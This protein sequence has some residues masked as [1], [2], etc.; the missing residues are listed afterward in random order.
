MRRSKRWKRCNVSD[1]SLAKESP[2][3]SR[4][5]Q[6]DKGVM[7]R[8]LGVKDLFAIGYG[9]LG[10][11][12]YYAL[13]VTALFALGATPISLLIAGLVFTCT[14]LT[15]AEI[16]AS[17]H[18]SGG[19]ASFA[20]HAFNDLISFIAGWGLLLDYVVT[21]AISSFAVAPYLA[22]FNHAFRDP[23]F[24]SVFTIV[25]IFILFCLNLLGVRQ[26]TRLSFILVTFTLITQLIIIVIGFV[27]L[28]DL[29]FIVEHLRINVPGTDWSPSW[30]SFWKGTAMA[31]VAY[32][33][34]ESIAQLGAEA[35]KPE[36]TSP[37]AIFLTMTV[38]VLMYIAISLVALSALPPKTL[39]TK[40]VDDPIA[41]I[42]S[43]LP[44][45]STVLSPWVGIL[46]AVLL[47]VAANAG[48]VGASRLAFNMGEY[49]QLPQPFY[50]L[51][52]RF[53]TPWVSLLCFAIISSLV[54]IWSRAQMD[55]LADLYNF[56]AMISFFFAHLS[57]IAMRIKQPDLKRP[58][59]IPFNIPFGRHRIPITAIIGC[60]AT[61]AVWVLVVIT[62]PDGRY[63]GFGWMIF[64][65]AMFLIYRHK[66]RIAATGQ[67][68][69]QKIQMPEFST[70]KIRNI[71][72]P[73]GG[74]IQIETVQMACE[75]ARLH[76]AKLIAVHVIQ[77]PSSLPLDTAVPN[78]EL[79][80]EALLKR[81][82]AIAREYRLP[83]EL[84]VLR[85]RSVANTIIELTETG[86]YDL[87]V[88]GVS[89]AAHRDTLHKMFG[90]TTEKIVRKA[91]CRVWIYCS[92]AIEEEGKLAEK[93][94]PSREGK[95]K[96][97]L[98]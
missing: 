89:T 21:I 59:R 3:T 88:L 20:R 76:N 82:E 64:G 58:Y 29:P 12:I 74:H 65:I 26:S 70:L 97:S 98:T 52:R 23:F 43:A 33:G 78:R 81:A 55:F 42:V 85:S 84:K 63:L 72:V 80:A 7:K 49:Y 14:A 32:T 94:E 11:S 38:L 45:G 41:G 24:H 68:S 39:A 30:P 2:P 79:R 95:N 87:L 17:F 57:L 44:F 86:E 47:F 18:E 93:L 10:S 53:R 22:Y 77:L 54:I 83:I 67:L 9:D 48:L 73:T 34:I 36:K 31:M 13:G 28:F 19:S 66:H 6:I 50:R 4:I 60:I 91:A 75:L 40:Y 1:C 90:S 62:K 71:L 37:R 51:H 35:K 5:A 46:A 69:I 27:Y 96:R 61:F 92:D 56:G 16:T 25:L 8:V 15:Y